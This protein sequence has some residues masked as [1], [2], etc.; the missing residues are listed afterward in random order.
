MQSLGSQPCAENLG[1][2]GILK[3]NPREKQGEGGGKPSVISHPQVQICLIPLFS[4][5]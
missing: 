1:L 3:K 5:L 2:V 4:L